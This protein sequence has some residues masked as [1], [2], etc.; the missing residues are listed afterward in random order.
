MKAAPFSFDEYQVLARRTQGNDYIG[1]YWPVM[2]ITAEAGEVAGVIK[3]LIYEREVPADQDEIDAALTEEAGDVL[4]YLALLADAMDCSLAE[5]AEANI[6]KLEE[7][8]LKHL[9]PTPPE[10][11][12][13]K[14]KSKQRR[15]NRKAAK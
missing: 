5:I 2:G 15:G 9:R 13:A 8:H 4:W 14:A 6:K 1:R 7:R 10:R 11:P 12:T 3:K